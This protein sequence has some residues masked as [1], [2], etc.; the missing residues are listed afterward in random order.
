MNRS[1]VE[2]TEMIEF[3]PV[4]VGEQG[5]EIGCREIAAWAKANEMFITAAIRYLHETKTVAAGLEPHCLGIDCNRTAAQDA[6]GQIF[7][8]EMN[9]HFEFGLSVASRIVAICPCLIKAA[10]PASK[11]LAVLTK[12]V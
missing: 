11:S 1:K 3:Q 5:L 4:R 6:L 2:T 12:M 8:M 9:S 10:S 7:F